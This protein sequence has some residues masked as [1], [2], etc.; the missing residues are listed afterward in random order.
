MRREGTHLVPVDA[1]LKATL[2]RMHM[3][4][5]LRIGAIEVFHVLHDADFGHDSFSVKFLC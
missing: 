3:H 2:V 4:L 1:N 5:L